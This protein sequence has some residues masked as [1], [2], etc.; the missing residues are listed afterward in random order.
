MCGFG[1]L[2]GGGG[3]GALSGRLGRWLPWKQ[4]D[5][6]C[7][8]WRDSGGVNCVTVSAINE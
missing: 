2:E 1:G 7:E 4:R 8:G 5:S 6:F 3:G